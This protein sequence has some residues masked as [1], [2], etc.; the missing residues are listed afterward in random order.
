MHRNAVPFG[1]TRPERKKIIKTTQKNE[2]R[3]TII[4]NKTSQ[5]SSSHQLSL[6]EDSIFGQTP[7][8]NG[9][10]INL[11]IKNEI[12][13][14]CEEQGSLS[15]PSQLSVNP[16]TLL[17]IPQ[18]EMRKIIETIL[19]NEM[20][21]ICKEGDFPTL[22]AQLS[23][24]ADMIAELSML[25]E[26]ALNKRI[27]ILEQKIR[28]KDKKIKSLHNLVEH[29]VSTCSCSAKELKGYTSGRYVDAS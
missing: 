3:G 10:T 13:N 26:T 5:C 15:L 12:N 14:V 4:D 1:N 16:Y 25:K 22:P 27:E 29:L 6:M 8:E 17:S 28:R 18:P 20:S 11:T 2:K 9:E 24:D 19:R 7:C 23:L 21:D